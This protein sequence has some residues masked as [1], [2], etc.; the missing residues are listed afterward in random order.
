[1]PRL[2]FAERNQIVGM[3]LSGESCQNISNRFNI[4]RSNVH[5]IL[6]K[7]NTHGTVEDRP[8]SG[9]PRKTT[10]DEDQR[11]VQDHEDQP[12]FPVKETATVYR[13]SVSTVRRRL[14]NAGLK[15]RRPYIGS[16][17]KEHHRGLRYDWCV[18]RDRWFQPQW[19]AV[20]FSDES[21]FN[22]S[23]ADGRL[24]IW[25][26]DGHRYSEN[27][28]LQANRFGGGSVMVWVGISTNHRTELVTVAGRL[29]AQTYVDTI[30]REHVVPIFN[31]HRKLKLFQ[32][33][34]ARPHSAIL[35]QRFLQAQRFGVLEW[36]SLSPDLSPIE[37]LWDELGRRVNRRRGIRTVR[38]LEDA[39]KEEYAAIPQY[40]I[41][42][43]TRSMRGRV[44]ECIAALGGHTRYWQLSR[45]STNALILSFF[46]LLFL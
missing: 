17:F 13:L 33:D 34:N 46:F 31:A 3:H 42:K 44:L 6:K 32:Q 21:K 39:L 38:E 1:M 2:S 5:K 37:H 45:W 4:E 36:P 43:L 27:C 20:L 19:D 15:C 9:R 41:A 12:F 40:L 35:T 18:A 25:R 11:I 22:V 10:N 24:R 29:N 16:P 7:Y 23:F 8:K 14:K 30:L 28:V 26:R